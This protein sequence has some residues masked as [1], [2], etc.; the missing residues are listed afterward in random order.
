MGGAVADAWPLAAIA[1]MGMD[2]NLPRMAEFMGDLCRQTGLQIV[3][4]THQNE[5]R[6]AADAVYRIEKS[7]ENT[8]RLVKER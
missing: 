7:G 2:E 3:L 4:V 5:F 1:L 6:D 8:A